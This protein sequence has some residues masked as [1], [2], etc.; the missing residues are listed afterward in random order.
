MPETVDNTDPYV[1]LW[2]FFLD[3][4][5]YDKFDLQIGQGKTLTTIIIKVKT[6]YCNNIYVNVVPLSTPK[7]SYCT[8]L[9]FL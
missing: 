8:A 9:T 4:H 7:I 6:M 2:V 5:S 1:I 3:I